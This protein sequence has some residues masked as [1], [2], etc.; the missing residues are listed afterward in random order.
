[1]HQPALYSDD[2][3]NL[4]VFLHGVIVMDI[5]GEATK[6]EMQEWCEQLR[7]L[8]GQ[9]VD[10]FVFCGRDVIKATGDL[11]RV[12]EATLSIPTIIQASRWSFERGGP[13][14]SPTLQHE[15]IN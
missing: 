7:A 10:W 1:M 8:S 2:I 13:T 14:V 9:P 12:K 6:K 3:C 5:S 15:N 11:N 4:D